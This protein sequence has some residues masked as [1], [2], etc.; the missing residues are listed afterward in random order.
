MHL[1]IASYNVHKCIGL[2]RKHDP[3]RVLR[4]ICAMDADIIA[5]QETKMQPE[6]FDGTVDGY[7]VFWNSAEKK[8]GILEGSP[9]TAELSAVKNKAYVVVPFPATEAGV[10]TVSAAASVADQLTKLTFEG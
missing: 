7:R 9:V 1:R 10:R 4:S 8:V 2:D 6:Q 3:V 5:L